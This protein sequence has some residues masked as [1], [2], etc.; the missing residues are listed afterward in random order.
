MIWRN[1]AFG[2][3]VEATRGA[4]VSA[5][6]KT[7]FEKTGSSFNDR[8][9]LVEDDGSVGSIVSSSDVFKTEEFADWSFDWYVKLNSL[10]LFLLN[11]LWN[12][13]TTEPST[14]VFSHNFT[15]L[16]S[17]TH[18]SLV[19]AKKDPISSKLYKLAMVKSFE[20][21]AEIGKIATLSVE[22]ESKPWTVDWTI[23]KSYEVDHTMLSRFGVF[24][25][26]NT[27]V[28]LD[29]T[30]GVCIRS[31]KLKFE[32]N[33]EKRGCISSIAPAEI[34]NKTFTVSW[35][36]EL[37]YLNDTLKDIASAASKKAILFGMTDTDTDLGGWNNPQLEF[38]FYRV[39]F[40]S[41]DSTQDNDEISTQTL[42]FKAL[43]DFG[44]SATLTCKLVN[45]LDF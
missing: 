42:N 4:W 31:F 23:T 19:I 3:W 35:T 38:R 40:T 33:T 27:Y 24:K 25:Y 18:P 43:Y 22:F 28:G 13:T 20:L 37:D 10:G 9:T 29:A 16:E 17:N 21:T 32:M 44:N 36:I 5:D 8:Y 6:I 26:A 30:S 41:W 34:F 1:I 15:V 14:G 7:W 11:V 2:L 39:A 45:T 12:K